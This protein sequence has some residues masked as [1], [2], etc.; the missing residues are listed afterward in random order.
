MKNIFERFYRPD[1]SRSHETGGFGLG[2]SIAKTIVDRSDGDIFVD[3][4][5]ETTT[6]TVRLKIA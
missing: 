1:A 4:N 3:S 5:D 2:L 6:F